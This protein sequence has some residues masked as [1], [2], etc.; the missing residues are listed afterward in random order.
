MDVETYC[1]HLSADGSLLVEAALR[2]GWDA[3]VPGTDWHVRT[4]FVHTG[5]VHRWASAIVDGALT[6]DQAGGSSRFDPGLPDDELPGWFH[7]GLAAL[8]TSLRD[9]PQDLDCFVFLRDLPATP[10][11]AR[12]QAH[13]TAIHRADL[14]AASGAVTAFDV[15]FAQDGLVELVGG[16][17]R[18]RPFACPTP[19][20][21]ALVATDGP[22]WRV[23]FG[24]ERNEVEPTPHPTDCEATVTGTSS[25]LYLWAW[26]RPAAVEV[27]GDPQVAAL[28]RHVAIT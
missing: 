19:G 2:A 6:R 17:S 12:R 20:T 23:A 1:G 4:M 18:G 15:D 14:E 8:L 5:A 7:D 25:D 22:G 13:E 11:W 10:F 3:P 21:L 26:N 24:G 9:A 16:F 27:T 28:W